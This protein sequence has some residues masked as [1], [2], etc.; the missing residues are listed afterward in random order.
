[1]KKFVALV[2]CLL[3]VGM[4]FVGC[5]KETETYFYDVYDY[6]NSKAE[7]DEDSQYYDQTKNITYNIP[8]ADAL[9]SGE[10]AELK[11]YQDILTSLKT[12]VH[13]L[14]CEFTHDPKLEGKTLKNAQSK[15]TDYKEQLKVY[16]EEIADFKNSK[17]SFETACSQLVGNEVGVIE[18]DEYKSFL[19]SFRE[20]I[21]SL[22][23]VFS[24]M[25]DCAEAM[26]FSGKVSGFKTNSERVNA[27]KENIYEA[28][29]LLARDYMY[30]CH[31]HNDSTQSQTYIDAIFDNYNKV[32]KLTIDNDEL[33]KDKS[34]ET[35]PKI[36]A[37]IEA[38]DT[39]LN[40]YKSEVAKIKSEMNEGRFRYNISGIEINNAENA[41]IKENHE[42]YLTLIN[43]TMKNLSKTCVDLVAFY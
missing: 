15:V 19:S 16:E 24:K 40:Y 41:V 28:K 6:W 18:K 23:D 37:K 7:A 13:Q 42:K 22:N 3:C 35:L 14:S 33:S 10:F 17:Y 4:I 38:L 25:Y 29:I 12:D 26:F 32:R 21:G 2:F 5:S 30:F 31:E 9:I 1:M 36:D 27:V 34:E 39:W 43:S 8:N 11:K 20:L